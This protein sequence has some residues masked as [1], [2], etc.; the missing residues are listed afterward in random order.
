[1]D[2]IKKY[3]EFINETEYST[4]NNTPGI[5][6]IELP[7]NDNMNIGSGDSIIQNKI[8]KQNKQ[9]NIIL[10]LREYLK[11]INKI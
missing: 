6:N 4:V 9:K 5:N 2:N 3:K 8:F 10:T 1:M 7:N 11:N